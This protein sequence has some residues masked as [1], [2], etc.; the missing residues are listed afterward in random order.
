MSHV[1][2]PLP[3]SST[4]YVARAFEKRCFDLLARREWVLL[5]GP[6]QHGKT[7]ALIRIRRSLQDAGFRCSLVDLQSMPAALNFTQLLEWFAKHIAA[8]FGQNLVEHAVNRGRLEDW[9]H[10]ATE[11]VSEPIVV[12]IDEASSIRDEAIRNSFYGQIRALKTSAASAPN[13]ANQIVFLFAGTFK[14]ESLVDDL[15]S[16][17]NVCR[18]VDTE[19]L[20]LEQ[21]KELARVLGEEAEAVANAVYSGVGGQPHLAQHLIGTV[22][23]LE[24]EGR[25]AAVSEELE[26]LELDGCDHLTGIFGAVMSDA[27][28][29]K[30]VNEVASNGRVA[31]DPANADYRF[32]MVLGLLKREGSF[33]TFRNELYR[34]VACASP[35][36]G[37]TG[38]TTAIVS[39]MYTLPLGAFAFIGDP[40]YREIC[41]SAYNGAVVAANAGHYR[42]TIVGFG[43][44]LEALLIDWI[45]RRAQGDVASAV[46]A[47]KV[48]PS[49]AKKVAFNG[50]EDE[51]DPSTWRLVNL[52]KVAR[53]LSGVRGPLDVPES[54]REMR[55]LVHPAL[56]KKGYLPETSLSPE[57]TAASGLVAMVMR[58]MQQ[59]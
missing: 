42:M 35:Q 26:A 41:H 58:D 12:L 6:R 14:P 22:E 13:Q 31:N 1:V 15:N 18:R 40:E 20:D 23:I 53:R 2:G 54:L 25:P 11:G 56:V 55:N 49:A 57:A 24:N 30:I 34:R 43:V 5:L 51:V 33:L 36:L 37:G 50:Y 16:P 59:P 17:F 32:L 28:L 38:A 27:K 7:S 45:S 21:V 4:S 9:L 19:D 48:D 8:S 10:L 46:A 39:P 29:T 52:M 47:A 3:L 44:A